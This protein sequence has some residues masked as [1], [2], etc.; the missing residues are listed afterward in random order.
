MNRPH[1]VFRCLLYLRLECSGVLDV[2]LDLFS[3]VLGLESFVTVAV[4]VDNV[5]GNLVI[6]SLV[7]FIQ[8]NEEEIE[9]GHNWW[10]HGD[11]LL[12]ERMSK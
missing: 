6:C 1:I 12:K 2:A 5:S 3:V 9:T 10:R 7:A 8:D 11:V 4:D